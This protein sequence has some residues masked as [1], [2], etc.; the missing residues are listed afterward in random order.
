MTEQG[1]LTLVRKLSEAES[2]RQ[3]YRSSSNTAHAKLWAEAM[4]E[5]NAIVEALVAAGYEMGPEEVR[6]PPSAA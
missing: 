4:A 2:R 1:I 3:L 6:P 5:F